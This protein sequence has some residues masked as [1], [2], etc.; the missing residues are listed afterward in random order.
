MIAMY[1][2]KCVCMQRLKEIATSDGIFFLI[3]FWE[4]IKNSLYSEI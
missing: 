3:V 2:Q 4:R 1:V